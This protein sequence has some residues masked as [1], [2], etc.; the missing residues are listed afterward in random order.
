MGDEVL[1][2]VVSAVAEIESAEK[3]FALVY[4]DYFFVVAPE[5]RQNA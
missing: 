1:G 2:S 3:H 5:G 4:D